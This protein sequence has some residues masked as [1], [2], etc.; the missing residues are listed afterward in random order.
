MM[1]R[2]LLAGGLA[3]LAVLGT[4]AG[5]GFGS[6]APAI[7]ALAPA[8]TPVTGNVTGPSILAWNTHANYFVNGTG[9]PAFAPNGTQVGNLTWWISLLAANSTGTTITPTEGAIVGGNASLTVLTVANITEPL[10]IA[11]MLSSTYLTQNVTTNFTYTL[12]I[13]QPYVVAATLVCG[14]SAGVASFAVTV[15]LDGTT[16]GTVTVPSL[17]ANQT[18]HLSYKYAVLSL[19]SGWHTFTISLASLHGLVRF[20]GGAT[21]YSQSFYVPGPSTSYTLWYVAGFVA[22]FGAIFILLTRVAARRRGAVKR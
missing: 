18:Y 2:G 4:L 10:T 12:H 13:V 21:V 3:L 20:S 1:R 11:V 8:S 5:A 15:Q 16:V 19:G 9:G 14:P 7:A 6:G 22:F 17:L